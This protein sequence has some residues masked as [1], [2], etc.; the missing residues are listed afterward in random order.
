MCRMKKLTM[1]TWNTCML[2][3][4]AVVPRLQSQRLRQQLGAACHA[5]NAGSNRHD[6]QVCAFT[7]KDASS[8]TCFVTSRVMTWQPR[9]FAGSVMVFCS[10]STA[11]AG[12]SACLVA[13]AGKANPAEHIQWAHHD[14][15]AAR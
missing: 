4:Q 8:G 14:T 11:G 7:S 9:D 10:H 3:I 13:A 1:P 5:Y 2:S 15:C 12:A 6:G